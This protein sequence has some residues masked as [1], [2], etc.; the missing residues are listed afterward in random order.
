M[1]V[2]F[3]ILT[4]KPLN[5][6]ISLAHEDK[7]PFGAY[8]LDEVIDSLFTDV[9]RS[10]LT[11][12]ERQDSLEENQLIITTDFYPDEEDLN[13]LLNHVTGGGNVL[14]S[15]HNFTPLLTDSLHFIV[16]D[17]IFNANF[18]QNLQE[19]DSSSLSFANPDIFPADSF[20]Y[21]RNNTYRRFSEI[22]TASIYVSAFNDLG[23]PV[24]VRVPMG[25]GNLIL[26]TTPLVFSNIYV[27]Y[28]D[29]HK[30]AEQT[31]SM[32]PEAPVHWAEYYMQGRR[33]SGTPLRYILKQPSLAWAYYLLLAALIIYMVIGSKRMQRIIPVIKPLR[34]TTLDFINT[35]SS[36][37]LKGK[38]HKSIA[39][40]RITYFL[41]QLRS[42]YYLSQHL[43]GQA[44]YEKIA[45]KSGHN[46]EEV[47]KLMT[48]IMAIRLKKEI[49]EEE[50]KRINSY[51]ED[52]KL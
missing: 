23:Q 28:N 5:W 47:E 44:L 35:V 33:E 41:D 48:S 46:V 42:K 17:Y 36:L 34:N 3:Q 15:A 52:F 22:D 26:N 11:T 1:Y 40:K 21:Q 13:I 49:S 14:I 24:T 29:N 19:N 16:D 30:F 8:V 4:P 10:Y 7:N 27:L 20:S 9:S 31:L 38:N 45:A 43:E 18:A 25:K 6:T 51:I 12:Y 39:D 37:Y 50:L 32:L 2:I